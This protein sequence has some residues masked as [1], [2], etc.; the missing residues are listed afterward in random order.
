MAKRGKT[1][2]EFCSFCGREHDKAPQMISSPDGVFICSD[3]VT[4]CA[5]MLDSNTS[6]TIQPDTNSLL[7]LTVP[8]PQE[9][10][11]HLDN[12]IV[13][14][15]HAKKVLA[16]AVHNHYKRL[17]YSQTHTNFDTDIEL[18][19][20][21][22]LLIGPTGSGK[23]LLAKTLA[24]KI[25]VPF[26][27]VDA[28]TLTEAGYVGED[29]E[30]II[31]RLVQAADY[32]I[33]KAQIGIIYVDEIDKIARRTE[34]V[35]I[36]RD[37][38]GEGV[39]QALLKILEGTVANV[40]PKG[41]RKHP[42]QE[43][44]KVNTSNILFICA[45][46]FIGMEKIVHRRMGKRVMGFGRT[47]DENSY[48]KATDAKLLELAEP[49]DMI[50]FGLIPEFTGRLP[51]ISSLKELTEKDLI[52]ILTST[53]NALIKQYQELLAMEDIT[54]TF[55]EDALTALAQKA[56]KKGTGARGL[57]SILERIML[58]I[59]FEVPSRKDIKECMITAEVV[60][61]GKSPTLTLTK[62]KNTRKKSA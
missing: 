60:N 13:G 42:Q 32:D 23:T 14:Q 48:L 31:L 55:T 11:D 9:L 18:E 3:C 39:Q 45:G 7:D 4:I 43:Y 22:V 17:Q 46:A 57:R 30:N 58:D 38:S 37:V 61:N 40:P 19:K 49:E 54:L 20:S 5:S 27:I 28:T 34:N 2:K 50:K 51:V 52:H 21:N 62:K 26:A 15:E 41:G 12:Y 56:I 44:L 35:S 1:K 47:S 33:N 8:K 6:N 29:V 59:M 25:D 10:K 53:K 16:V 36:T 24:K